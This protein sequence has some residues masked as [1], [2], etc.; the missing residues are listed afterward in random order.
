[1]A[2]WRRFRLGR[3]AFWSALS[4][5]WAGRAPCVSATI[6]EVT[7]DCLL[8][9][10]LQSFGRVFDASP[11]RIM[12]LGRQLTEDWRSAVGD[13]AEGVRMVDRSWHL[14]SRAAFGAERLDE[15]A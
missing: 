15:E 14:A 1:V 8:D 13:V 12:S 6:A 10:P 3:A 11:Q 9:P 5:L 7:P 2:G 4:V